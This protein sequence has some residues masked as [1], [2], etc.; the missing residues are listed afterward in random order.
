MEPG[1]HLVPLSEL[2]LED[3]YNLSHPVRPDRFQ[4]FASR[5]PGLPGIIVNQHDAVIF[6]TDAYHFYRSRKISR[7]R[8]MKINA[9]P[10]EGLFLN[11]NLKEKLLGLNLF[12]T[13]VFLK[14][15]LPLSSLGEIRENTDLKI[16]VNA[17]LIARLPL[18]TGPEFLPILTGDRLH[19]KSALR[20][21]SWKRED[22]RP[23]I[24]F[25]NRFRFSRSHQ[26][27]II[28]VTEELMF[29]DQLSAS[30][31]LA[32]LGPRTLDPAR[33]P[34]TVILQRMESLRYPEVQKV[35]EK[36]NREVKKLD[37]PPDIQINHPPFFEKKKIR[38]SMTLTDLKA[39]ESLL[40]K[41][42]K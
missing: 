35:R 32:K 10:R 26:L 9:S 29:R 8:V 12:E 11:F 2:K 40:E 42:K 38:L 22:R 14:R 34:Q 1:I 20:L 5:F 17:E 6:G 16:A 25:F 4:R 28:D 31:V 23:L 24:A 27:Q 21:C 37:L 19:L 36:W 7:V 39:L 13:L 30:R 33:N 3:T 15:A 41:I 18:L